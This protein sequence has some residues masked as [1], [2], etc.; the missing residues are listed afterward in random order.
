MVK[1]MKKSFYN[2][3]IE[4]KSSIKEAMLKIT[5]NKRGIV[6]VSRGKDKKIVGS[7]TDGDIRSQLIKNG[8]LHQKITSCYNRN[9]KFFIE[10]A[11]REGLLKFFDQNYKFIP[12]ISK[13]GRLLDLVYELNSIQDKKIIVRARSPAR[14]SLAGGGTDL[15]KFFFDKGGNGISFTINKYCNV[16]LIKRDDK[17]IRIFS[18]DYKKLLIFSSIKK[19]KY[20]GS[21][22]LIKASIKLTQP[23]FGF[24]IY[25]ETDVKPGS[26][27]GG[28]A[29]VTTSI[30]GALNYLQTRKLSKYEI[31]EYA[32][33]AER[34]ELGILGGWQDQYS[35]VFGGCNIMEFK[36][37]KNLVHNIKLPNN[38]L[39][40]LERRLIICNTKIPHRGL[41]MQTKN[42]K[43]SNLNKYGEEIKKIVELMKSDLLKGNIENLGSLI[44]KTWE[45][46]KCLDKKMSNKTIENLEKKLC[47][48][49]YA[50]GCR[51]LGTGGGGYMLLYVKPGNRFSLMSKIRAEKFEH[52][53]IKFD[54]EGLKIWE[55]EDA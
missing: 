38:I 22:D 25:V 27:L 47:G 6:F 16:H 46:K 26:G 3:I 18:M 36:K 28:S 13:S 31:A 2:F 52:H 15:T 41:V 5:K 45:L 17:K 42:K 50:S 29:A 54:T 44:Q 51:L 39:D 9:F 40:E 1:I 55:T 49:K 33:Q 35:T 10:K 7:L 32:F 21:L 30:I 43:N 19:I 34:I 24:D 20:N 4:E 53:D 23:E 8:D 12:V 11:D 37:E 14:I 48:P